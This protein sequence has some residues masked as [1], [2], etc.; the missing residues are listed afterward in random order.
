MGTKTRKSKPITTQNDKAMAKKS[1]VKK[2]DQLN[3]KDEL[4]VG[5]KQ[6]QVLSLLCRPEG[7]TVA[8]IMK[9]TGWQQHSVRGFLAG[10]VRRKLNL[11]VQSAKSDDQRIYRI[12]PPKVGKARASSQA[13]DKA[14]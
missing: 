1:P 7:A 2:K 10:V 11:A 8:A 4:R 6:D 9:A 5:T 14:A 3:K 13:A 12:V